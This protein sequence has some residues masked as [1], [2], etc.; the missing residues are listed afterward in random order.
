[1][2][3]DWEADRPRRRKKSQGGL[4]LDRVAEYLAGLARGQ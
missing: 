2:E 4:P 1:M 3:R